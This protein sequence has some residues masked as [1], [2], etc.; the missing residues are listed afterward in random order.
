[1]VI[2]MAVGL[3][4]YPSTMSVNEFTQTSWCDVDRWVNQSFQPMMSDQTMID[5]LNKNRD[6]MTKAAE[7]VAYGGPPFYLIGTSADAQRKKTDS[8]NQ[9]FK[10]AGVVSFQIHS[11]YWSDDPYSMK[12]AQLMKE[13]D[14]FE[15]SCLSATKSNKERIEC[16]SQSFR[17]APKLNIVSGEPNFGKTR[18]ASACSTHR[19]TVKTYIYFPGTPPRIENNKIKLHIGASG[20]IPDY[21]LDLSS[22]TDQ[23]FDEAKVRQIDSNWFISN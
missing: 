1:M 10:A 15:K 14:V 18:S 9:L 19:Q 16:I 5:H 6:A 12:S 22:S 2:S 7:A 23:Y 20:A 3:V 4:F 17:L 11:G 21:F 8:L 13:L